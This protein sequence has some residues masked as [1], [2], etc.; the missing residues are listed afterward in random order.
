MAFP[1][2]NGQAEVVVVRPGIMGF[3]VPFHIFVNGDRIGS[4][5]SNDYCEALVDPG[6]VEVS[7]LAETECRAKFPVEANRSYFLLADPE[8]GWM[9]SRVNL[10]VLDPMEGAE[11]RAEC[12]N[13]TIGAEGSEE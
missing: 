7:A 9:S 4:I 5:R 2:G 12:E 1:A 6:V 13:H 3:A 8:S 11:H 10:E